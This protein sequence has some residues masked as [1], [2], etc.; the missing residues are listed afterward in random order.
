MHLHYDIGG[1]LVFFKCSLKSLCTQAKVLQ[2]GKPNHFLTLLRFLDHLQP[3]CTFEAYVPPLSY[4]LSLW[5]D[6][7]RGVQNSEKRSA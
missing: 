2:L 5:E 1:L 4:L 7:R 6:R 3:T